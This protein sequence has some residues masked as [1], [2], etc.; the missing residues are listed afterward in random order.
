M[1][2]QDDEFPKKTKI[3]EKNHKIFRILLDCGQN[4]KSSLIFTA[5]IVCLYGSIP[6]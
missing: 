1:K 5:G 6:L 2:M 3:F 4:R